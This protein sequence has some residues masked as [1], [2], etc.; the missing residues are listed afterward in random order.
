MTYRPQFKRCFRCILVPSEGVILQSERG[1]LLLRDPIYFRLA[2]LLNGQHTVDE[3]ITCLHGQVSAIEA[4]YALELLHHRGYVVEASPSVPSEQAAFWELLDINPQDAIKRLQETVVS[5]F[6]YGEIDITPLYAML[7]AL[8]VS[9]STNG[10]YSIILTDDYLRD[11]LD[12]FNR[13]AL[14]HARPWLLVKPVGTEL[15]IGPLFVPGRT[16][17]WACLAHRLQGARKV[18]NYLREQVG[19]T[20]MPVLSIAALPSTVSTALSIAATETAKWIV[21]G[22]N[23]SVEGRIVTFNVLSLDKQTHTLIKRPQCPYC[24]DPAAFTASQSAPLVLQSR[25]KIFTGD[26]GHRGFA[27]E[28]TFTTLTHHISPI[29]GIVGMLRPL[30]P[31]V[32]EGVLPLLS[33][34]RKISLTCQKRMRT[35]WTPL[36]RACAVELEAKEDTRRKPKSVP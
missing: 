8:S 32:G 20:Q 29:T 24:G 7:S 22:Q 23:E 26:G 11:E 5:V 19:I 27:P 2:P 31:L 33:W 25:K 9:V 13:E 4:L 3:I 30:S 21:R 14:V 34:P 28:E 1:P 18:D 16:G 10:S 6:T 12:S 17:C 35:T 36:V 15:W